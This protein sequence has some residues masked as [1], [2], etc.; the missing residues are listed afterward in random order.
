MDIRYY[1]YVTRYLTQVLRFSTEESQTVAEI[2]Q[3][4]EESRTENIDYEYDKVPEELTKRGIAIDGK[5]DGKMCIPIPKTNW[6]IDAKGFPNSDDCK[7]EENQWNS[8]VPFHYYPQKPIR[9]GYEEDKEYYTHAIKNLIENEGF[10]KLLQQ[11]KEQY[12]K[13]CKEIKTSQSTQMLHQSAIRIGVLCHVLSDTFAHSYLNGFE[14]YVNRTEIV[15]VKN[16]DTYAFCTE[17]YKLDNL[18][19]QPTVGTAQLGNSVDDCNITTVFKQHTGEQTSLLK[20]T[21]TVNTY[22]S[23]INGAKAVYD[24]LLVIRGESD[25]NDQ[26]WKGTC[27]PMLSRMFQAAEVTVDSIRNVLK[28]SVDI[29]QYEYDFE[30]VLSSLARNVDYISELALAV[31]DVRKSV[32]ADAGIMTQKQTQ[33]SLSMEQNCIT[34]GPVVM[35]SESFHITVTAL[36]EDIKEEVSVNL[37]MYNLDTEEQV[38]SEAYRQTSTQNELVA[39]VERMI[40]KRGGRYELSAEVRTD[41]GKCLVSNSFS[42]VMEDMLSLISLEV[43]DPVSKEDT[44]YVVNDFI[45]ENASYTYAEN[46]IY[47]SQA[48]KK[49]LDIFL[50]V[51]VRANIDKDYKLVSL[52]GYQ[53]IMTDENHNTYKHCGNPKFNRISCNREKNTVRIRFGEEWKNHI[54][55]DDYKDASTDVVLNVDLSMDLQYIGENPDKQGIRTICWSSRDLMTPAFKPLQLEW[56]DEE[57]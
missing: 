25:Y 21:H 36:W 11:A 14:T 24:M 54:M 18:K 35:E 38:Y 40:P 51:S 57:L 33:E 41:K 3:F 27:L 7:I 12:Q 43:I 44:I 26:N 29:N 34:F 37:Q 4:I 56:F 31:D 15:Q 47:V 16:N 5:S 9:K 46:A 39:I 55:C 19:A 2:C 17:K 42:F 1:Y 22:N 48:N 52:N 20:A 23:Y 49:Q 8:F 28:E 50:P 13:A 10:A 53:L 45:A 32:I 6:L 30:S